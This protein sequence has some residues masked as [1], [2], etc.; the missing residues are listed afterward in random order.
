MWL[1][2]IER[3]LE[4]TSNFDC[5]INF[6]CPYNSF[7]S[8]RFLVNFLQWSL[9]ATSAAIFATGVHIF[10]FEQCWE[11][12]K[13]A[14]FSQTKK[15]TCHPPDISRDCFTNLALAGT[16]LIPFPPPAPHLFHT[17][18]PFQIPTNFSSF[19]LPSGLSSS[20]VIDS[21]GRRMKRKK[22]LERFRRRARNNLR[23][24]MSNLQS[25][26]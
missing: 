14:A 10:Y 22:F 25:S 26:S 12:S 24:S 7:W 3:Y 5:T 23:N 8:S 4:S 11:V 17:L 20:S 18:S 9:R 13:T 15:R 19:S 2:H 16:S 21:N 1:Y 6:W